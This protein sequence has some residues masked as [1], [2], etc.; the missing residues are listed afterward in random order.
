MIS[1]RQSISRF[2]FA[3]N[4]SWCDLPRFSPGL[5]RPDH[6]GPARGVCGTCPWCRTPQ[7]AFS[8]DSGILVCWAGIQR[9]SRDPQSRR[10]AD[11]C[12]QS[13]ENT[14]RL[15]QVSQQ[16]GLDIALEALKLYKERRKIK[17]NELLRYAAVCRVPKDHPIL[18]GSAAV[19]KPIKSLTCAGRHSGW[20]DSSS[21][22]PSQ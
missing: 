3:E 18:S 6:P 2:G 14:G 8:A 16:I 13:R 22:R 19:K 9:R 21:E 11:S 7:N 4:L 1:A 10:R 17:T 15:L 20:E 5:P 12:L